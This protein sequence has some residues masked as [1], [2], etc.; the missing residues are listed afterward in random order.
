MKTECDG[1]KVE[2]IVI[3]KMTCPMCGMTLICISKDNQE[4]EYVHEQTGRK[5]CVWSEE[6]ERRKREELDKL[7]L[8]L[9]IEY[10]LKR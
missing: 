10:D 2:Y 5:E 7:F 3:F 9:H 4:D 8:E 1:V 6:Y